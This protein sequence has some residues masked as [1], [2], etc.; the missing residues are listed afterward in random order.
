[1]V[2]SFSSLLDLCV[3]PISFLRKYIS[4][5]HS[6]NEFIQMNQRK[7]NVNVIESGCVITEQANQMRYQSERYR[8]KFL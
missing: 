2:I 5:Q 4:G 7:L 8:V 3:T 6:H 1:M